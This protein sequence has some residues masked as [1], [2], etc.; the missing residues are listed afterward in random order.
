MSVATVELDEPT[1]VDDELTLVVLE[2]IVAK[3][4]DVVER[5]LV[6]VEDRL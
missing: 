2:L 4:L 6:L 1:A 3:L 5:T